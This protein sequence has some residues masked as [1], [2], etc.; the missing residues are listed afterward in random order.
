MKLPD[1][2]NN[3]VYTSILTDRS[4]K[5]FPVPPVANKPETTKKT[6]KTM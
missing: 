5:I 6:A 2:Q 3:Q 4:E 1:F